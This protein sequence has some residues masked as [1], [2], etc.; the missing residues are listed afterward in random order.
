MPEVNKG[1]SARHDADEP[2][3]STLHRRPSWLLRKPAKVGSI[4]GLA[5]ALT[6]GTGVALASI[7]ASPSGV[8][9]AC[10]GPAIGALRVIDAQAGAK[11][12][13]TEKQLTW[14]QTGPQ[15]AAG[16]QGPAGPVGAPGPAGATGQQGPA[17][18]AGPE[19]PAGASGSN[20]NT[21]LSGSGAPADS[22]G[23]N[24]DFYLDTTAE[25]VYGPKANGSWP[26]VGVSLVGPQGADGQTGA[27]G[28][29]GTPGAQGAAG[30]TGAI[31]P[32][33]VQGSAGPTGSTGLTGAQGPAGPAGPSHGY[34]T[35]FPFI[36]LTP[37]NAPNT[38]IA[39]LSLPAGNYMVS[40]VGQGVAGTNATAELTCSIS[41][42]SSS[43]VPNSLPLTGLD[44]SITGAADVTLN[45][46]GSVT[47]SCSYIGPASSFVILRGAMTAVQVGGLN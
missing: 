39:T 43:Y 9:T 23:S 10:Y 44:A 20:G 25:A 2:G 26:A 5:V 17:G 24:G 6:V 46:P 7:P 27:E 47:F 41:P 34:I 45:S 31:G 36:E 8:I 11:C 42:S 40:V 16:A 4:V 29:A 37:P 32:A 22:I 3:R 15:G 21:V 1:R 38:T 28:P 13:K 33:G 18:V 35:T 19:G 30:P 12:T 14:N